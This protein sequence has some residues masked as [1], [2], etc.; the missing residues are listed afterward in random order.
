[1]QNVPHTS[2]LQNLIAILPSWKDQ[3]L[4]LMNRFNSQPISRA[5]KTSMV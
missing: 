2:V 1:M 4:F 3:A 5:W